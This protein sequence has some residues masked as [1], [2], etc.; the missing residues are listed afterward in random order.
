MQKKDRRTREEQA[1]RRLTVLLWIAVLLLCLLEPGCLAM[2]A[3]A[4]A[5]ETDQTVTWLAAVGA[6]W[7][8]W[9]AMTLVLKL[10]EPRRK[11]ARRG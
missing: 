2:D 3:A 5:V 11:R 9:R 4:A 8:T 10:D 1:L 6:G 7:L